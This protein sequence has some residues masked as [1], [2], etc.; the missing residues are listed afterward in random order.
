MAAKVSQIGAPRASRR[1]APIRTE[2]QPCR[3][4]PLSSAGPPRGTDLRRIIFPRTS[5]GIPML[6]H[7]RLTRAHD[8][9][10]YV[11]RVIRALDRRRLGAVALVTLL[12]SVGPYFSP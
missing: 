3:N 2:P 8:E 10:P 7:F 12:L 11:R 4:L 6:G 9:D 1:T 5:S